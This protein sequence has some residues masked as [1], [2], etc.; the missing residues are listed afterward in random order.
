MSINAWDGLF[1][2][3]PVDKKDHKTFYPQFERMSQF[4]DESNCSTEVVMPGLKD[5][6]V[7][8]RK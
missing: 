7:A 4:M 1:G 3:C 8:I 5:P 2:G 6:K